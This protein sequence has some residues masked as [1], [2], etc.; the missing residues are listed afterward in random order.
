MDLNELLRMQH[1]T[2]LTTKVANQTVQDGK[3]LLILMQ[4]MV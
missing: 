1:L 2:G 3:E 4:K